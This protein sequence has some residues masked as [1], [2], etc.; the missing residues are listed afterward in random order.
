MYPFSRSQT[1][2]ILTKVS[3]RFTQTKA[4]PNFVFLNVNNKLTTFK[5]TKHIQMVHIL[6][7]VYFGSVADPTSNFT[8]VP[9][10]GKSQPLDL[11][12][13]GFF[14]GYVTI[15]TASFFNFRAVNNRET[16]RARCERK[17]SWSQKLSKRKLVFVLVWKAI[18]SPQKSHFFLWYPVSKGRARFKFF[19][20]TR[21]IR[22][23][24][25]L[26]SHGASWFVNNPRIV[27]EVMNKKTKIL[28]CT[29]TCEALSRREVTRKSSF[30]GFWAR[31][32]YRSKTSRRLSGT[33]QRQGIFRNIL[34]ERAPIHCLQQILV[35]VLLVIQIL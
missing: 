6:D 26:P 9:P 21:F 2:N 23:E 28:F 30:S 12:P 14:R 3:R 11:P 34:Q 5:V 7:V 24:T 25:T 16:F 32:C 17:Y 18:S 8:T 29:R 35:C 1:F 27:T 4:P 22:S 31:K 10:P 15:F 20:L 13:R 19:S 33:K